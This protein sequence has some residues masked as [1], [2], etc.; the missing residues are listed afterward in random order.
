V[1]AGVTHGEHRS[2]NTP[3]GMVSECLVTPE[4]G[5]RIMSEHSLTSL[6]RAH[7]S[8]TPRE[9]QYELIRG[10]GSST[11]DGEEFP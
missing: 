5:V 11:W 7:A 9:S 4:C 2:H 6:V 1:R 10:E 3:T 8:T